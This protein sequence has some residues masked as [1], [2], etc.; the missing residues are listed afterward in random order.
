V[1]EKILKKG[2]E[3]NI[4]RMRGGGIPVGGM[5]PLGTLVEIQDVMNHAPSHH[6]WMNSF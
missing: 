6:H 5:M 2:H 3:R 4:S 1:P